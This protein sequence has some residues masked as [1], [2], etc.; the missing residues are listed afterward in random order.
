MNSRESED[1]RRR[2]AQHSLLSI[3]LIFAGFSSIPPQ[4]S[5]QEQRAPMPVDFARIRQAT[6]AT[7]SPGARYGAFVLND[8]GPQQNKNWTS[9]K[10]IWITA[11]GRT[12]A[13][14]Q[15][16]S[17]L[18]ESWA[19]QWSANG[20][21]LAF[22]AR[23]DS[24]GSS[25]ER[26]DP[27]QLFVSNADGTNPQQLTNLKNGVAEFRW[28]PNSQI[29]AFTSAAPPSS[30]L[31]LYTINL[32]ERTPQI[33]LESKQHIADFS[34][35]QTSST[36]AILQA[37]T[38]QFNDI[39][40]SSAISLVDTTTKK[41]TDTFATKIGYF[42]GLKFSPDGKRILYSAPS[43]T[44]ASV[45]AAILD[46]RTGKSNLLLP[47]NSESLIEAQWSADSQT[48]YGSLLDKNNVYISRIDVASGKVE[49]LHKANSNWLF[50]SPTADFSADG[51]TYLYLKETARDP[52]DV[53]ISKS[54]NHSKI[55]HLNPEVSTLQLHPIQEIRWQNS[56]DREWIHGMLITPE[57]Q[58]QPKPL[59]LIT[60]IHGGPYW[61]WWNGWQE[62]YMGWGQL[63]ASN[64]YAVF[65]P[66]PRGSDGGGEKYADAIVENPG[67]V[68]FKDIISGIDQLIQDGIA[69]PK[70]LG[71][72]GFSYGGFMTSWAIT[73]TDRFKAAV[74]GGIISDWE[75]MFAT[76]DLPDFAIRTLGGTPTERPGTYR[77][78]SP[79]KYA[80]QASTPTLLYQGAEDPRTP[81]SEATAFHQ[82]LQ[83]AGTTTELILF[84]GE[85]HYFKDHNNTIVLL[86]NVLRWFNKYLK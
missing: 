64:G 57:M 75:S 84:E 76:S 42:S 55:T 14:R 20:A 29:I 18:S 17:T 10:T 47:D 12:K 37:P 39:Q 7:I 83:E 21:H 78:W 74:A 49:H 56:E 44:K 13:W 26:R 43:R 15:P 82:A 81:P 8:P 53:W 60:L 71:I 33:A 65:L 69:D 35:G 66:N 36:L 51:E 52:A 70:R 62:G 6:G 46:V 24:N 73:Q 41:I 59:P 38:S 28:A 80:T 54:G 9:T 48:L 86:N 61:A 27:P 72:G 34:W 5:A 2:I 30:N 3:A 19:P 23:P 79:L 58:G 16:F 45:R 31:S 67:G 32:R 68:D 63:L 11:L 1:S 25:Q 4:A 50:A 77:A 85:D 22:L 40:S